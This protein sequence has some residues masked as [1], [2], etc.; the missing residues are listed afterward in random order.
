MPGF[1]GDANPLRSYF[2][3]HTLPFT[4][5]PPRTETKAS[6]LPDILCRSLSFTKACISPTGAPIWAENRKLACMCTST[7]CPSIPGGS[8]HLPLHCLLP[9]LLSA[10]GLTTPPA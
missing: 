3:A 8:K 9:N 1:G 5:P 4:P 6:A 2:F 7:T 10:S